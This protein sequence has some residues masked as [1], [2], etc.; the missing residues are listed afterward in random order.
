[1]TEDNLVERLRW[2]HWYYEDAGENTSYTSEAPLEAADLIET[3]AREI[4]R[5]RAVLD[6][7]AHESSDT[8]ARRDA[9]VA[10]GIDWP[11]TRRESHD[12]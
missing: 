8:W 7:I 5:L 11:E 4:E 12:Q 2:S 3:Q 6:N 10:L 1:M 9:C